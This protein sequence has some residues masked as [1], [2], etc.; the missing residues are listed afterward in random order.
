MQKILVRLLVPV[1]I[2][3][4]WVGV[5]SPAFADNSLLVPCS[6]SAA[7]QERKSNAPDSYYF[8]KP[9]DVYGSELVC[10]E[11]GLP[12]LDL[13]AKQPIDVLI[14]Y[15]IFFYVAGFIGWSGRAYLQAANKTKNPEEHE[16]F[17]DIPLAISSFTKGLLWPILAIQELATGQLTA[18]EGEIP[19]SPR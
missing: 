12:H 5:V 8:N 18:K 3:M 7:F 14:P 13:G 19:V 4:I 17:I 10:G 1:I 16:I 11:D 9:F 2:L 15:G 6:Q